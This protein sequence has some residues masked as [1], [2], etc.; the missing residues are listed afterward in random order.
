VARAVFEAEHTDSPAFL[1]AEAGRARGSHP[2]ERPAADDSQRRWQDGARPSDESK[3]VGRRRPGEI[4]EVNS[5]LQIV[6][7]RHEAL[8]HTEEAV[9]Q[10]AEMFRKLDELSFGMRGPKMELNTVE[11]LLAL[12]A[13]AQARLQYLSAVVD[14]NRAQ[15]QLY[16]AMGQPSLEAFPDPPPAS[17]DVPPQSQPHPGK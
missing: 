14:Y 4:D 7:A 3:L 8:A 13:L 10:A 17:R 5:A 6:L 9:R 2:A 11:P 12:Q 15:F 1:R 16:T